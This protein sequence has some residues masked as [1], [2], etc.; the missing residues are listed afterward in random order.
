MTAQKQQTAQPAPD[1]HPAGFGDDADLNRVAERYAVRVTTAVYDNIAKTAPDDPVALQYLPDAR[2]LSET[3]DELPDPIGDHSHSPTPGIVHRY[4]D[5]VLLMP[6]S[7]CAVYCRYCFRREKVGKGAGLLEPAQLAAALDY[8][9]DNKNIWEVILSG[10]D[11]L[12]LSPR[13]LAAIL[14]ELDKIGHVGVIRIHS[15]VPIADPDRINDA[16]C[17]VLSNTQK[18]VYIAVHIN[19]AQELTAAVETALRHLHQ[20]GCTLLSQSVLLKGVNN[21]ATVLETLFRRLVSLRV[22]PYYLHHPDKA[23]GTAHFR[24]PLAEGQQIMR[25]LRGRLSGLA[26]PVYMLDIP[27]GHGKIPLTPCYLSAED[28]GIYQVSDPS[29]HTHFYQD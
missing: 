13:R 18:P 17:A 9:R 7:R 16:L 22:R 25:E 28:D 8:I 20:A 6:V 21:D 15:R 11:P 19:H 2:E 1:N 4:P 10:G 27:G 14:E 24:L 5:R 3:P 26:Q 12:I 29:G 23:P